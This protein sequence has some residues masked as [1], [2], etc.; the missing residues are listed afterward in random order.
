M[1]NKPKNSDA[2][3]AMSAAALLCLLI[4]GAPAGAALAQNE[5]ASPQEQVREPAREGAM[6][7]ERIRDRIANEQGLEDQDRERLRQHLAECEQLG[8][9]DDITAALFAEGEPLKNQMRTQERVLAMA[10][11]GLPVEPVMQKLQEGR[12]KGANHERLEQACARMEEHVRA[13]DRIMK[14]TRADGVQASVAD[15]ERRHTGEVAICMWSG[16]K[17]ADMDQLR[18]RAR[19]RLRDGTCTTE[20]FAAAAET[21]SRLHEMHIERMRAL[22]LAGEA[23]QNGYTARDMQQLR[24]MVMSAHLH[25]GPTDEVLDTLEDGLRNQHQMTYMMRQMQQHGWMGPADEHGG[26]GGMTPDHSGGSGPGGG[27]H[28]GGGGH[29]GDKKGGGGNH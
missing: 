22:G 16:L 15:A 8:L 11:D 2:F 25:G 28:G 19:L 18:E 29:G 20:D 10:R 17:E 23:L 26:R 1:K 24:W 21:A 27:H 12:R 9:N 14:Q 3:V 6:L 5:G 7:R 13:A 4:A